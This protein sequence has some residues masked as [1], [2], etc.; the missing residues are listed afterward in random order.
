LEVDARHYCPG[1]LEKG[2]QRG[3]IEV[4]ER[5]RK[6]YDQVVFSLLLLPLLTCGFLLPVSS[7][8][9]LGVIG[10]GW[11]SPPSRLVRT[12]LRLG[13]CVPIALAEFAGGVV[14]WA[15]VFRT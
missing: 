9:A 13:V 2:R 10:W 15:M 12:R 1:C 8:A 11:R 14:F 4:I 6:R 3:S 7:V 5:R